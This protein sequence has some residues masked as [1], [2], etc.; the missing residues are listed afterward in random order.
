MEIDGK[1]RFL[2]HRKYCLKC[3]P[4]GSHSAYNLDKGYKAKGRGE[5]RTY[6][7]KTC[8][9][10]KTERWR[11]LE[12]SS[13]RGKRRRDTNRQKAIEYKGGG[14]CIC[15]Y[16]KCYYSLD[17]HHLDSEEKEMQISRNWQRSWKSLKAELDKCILVCRNCHGE[18]HAGITTAK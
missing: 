6:K 5:K 17:F 12:C 14:C 10:V 4:F 16:D 18:I 9:K 15:G 1:T 3:S 7:C 8:G 11:N 2:N 13:C